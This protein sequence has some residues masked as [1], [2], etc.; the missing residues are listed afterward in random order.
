M[1]NREW[2]GEP[3]ITEAVMAISKRLHHE[4]PSR[5][6]QLTESRALRGLR[7]KQLRTLER[8]GF[9][10]RVRGGVDRCTASH[11]VR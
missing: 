2:L 7:L 4:L 6:S 9:A 11:R 3:E 10:Y 8:H 5:P 1:S